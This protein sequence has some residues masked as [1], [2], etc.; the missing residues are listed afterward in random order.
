MGKFKN[1]L[2]LLIKVFMV[3]IDHIRRSPTDSGKK[4]TDTYDLCLWAW[5]R[6]AWRL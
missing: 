4:Q 1:T 3:I 6:A 2:P 5:T